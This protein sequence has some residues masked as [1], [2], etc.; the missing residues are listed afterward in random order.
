MVA[1]IDV[2]GG[3]IVKRMAEV[4]KPAF[5]EDEAEEEEVEEPKEVR[6]DDG[7][8][9]AF[10]KNP[11]LGALIRPTVRAEKGKGKSG[12]EEDGEQRKSTWRRVQDDNDDNEQWILDGGAYGGRVEGR[13]LGEEE[14]AFG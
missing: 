11:L 8:S 1:S 7:G 13:R 10:S 4:E 12:G 9:G 2:V 14:H 6:R 5:S 3:K